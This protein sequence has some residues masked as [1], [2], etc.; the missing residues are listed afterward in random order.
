MLVMAVPC[1]NIVMMFVWAFGSGTK[2]SKAN[3]FRA[4]LIMMGVVIGIYLLLFLIL[5]VSIFT[6]AGS[7]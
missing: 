7:Y 4:T 2:K 3:Y 5:G 1:V 6:L